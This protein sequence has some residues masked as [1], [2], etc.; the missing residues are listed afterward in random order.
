ME[1]ELDELTFMWQQMGLNVAPFHKCFTCCCQ[2][3]PLCWLKMQVKYIGK[4]VLSSWKTTKIS[5]HLYYHGKR[6]MSDLTLLYSSKYSMKN[7]VHSYRLQPK[8]EGFLSG[9]GVW[10]SC[11]FVQSFS[12]LLH[13]LTLCSVVQ[14]EVLKIPSGS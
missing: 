8:S 12:I 11:C 10:E 9:P 5:F 13:L 4:L 3:F 14:S 6:P 7:Y 2:R 1:L